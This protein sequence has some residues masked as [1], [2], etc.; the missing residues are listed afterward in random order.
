M[1]DGRHRSYN[2]T[3]NKGNI[4]YRSRI[5]RKIRLIAKDDIYLEEV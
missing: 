2:Y 1:G 3:I 4:D 5:Y